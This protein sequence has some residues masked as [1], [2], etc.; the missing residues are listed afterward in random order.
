MV[1]KVHA[2]NDRCIAANEIEVPNNLIDLAEG[3]PCCDWCA[4]SELQCQ[5]VV[6][7]AASCQITG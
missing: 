4:D 7:D 1:A 2:T 5:A 3:R 6:S